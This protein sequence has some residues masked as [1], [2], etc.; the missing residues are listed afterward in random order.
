[1]TYAAGFILAFVFALYW[2]P[3]MRK[4]AKQLG[5]VDK[6]DGA[7]KTQRHAT[8]YLGGLAVFMAFLLTVGVFTDFGQETLGLLLSGSIA[9][10]VGLLD[11][12]GAMTPAQ[13]LLGQA[14]AALVL[15]KSGIYI[16]LEFIPIW[17]A[18]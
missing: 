1:M 18:I 12:F 3:L 7:L 13:K 10:M 11:D 4:A 5:V 17:L 8:P 6:P 14:L 16:K 9:L 2:T 15:I